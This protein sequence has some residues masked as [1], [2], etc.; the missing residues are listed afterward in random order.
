MEQAEHYGGTVC[1]IYDQGRALCKPFDY[2][3]RYRDKI[4][5]EPRDNMDKA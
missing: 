3:T 5:S 1:Q 4:L 2:L